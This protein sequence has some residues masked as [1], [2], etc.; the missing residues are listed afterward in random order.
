MESQLHTVLSEYLTAIMV[1][2]YWLGNAHDYGQYV[3]GE[4][5]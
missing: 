5:R 3:G 4:H 2:L 1:E